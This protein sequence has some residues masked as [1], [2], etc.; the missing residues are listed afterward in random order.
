MAAGMVTRAAR[1]NQNSYLEVQAGNRENKLE[2]MSFKLSKPFPKA[3]L[4]PT[5]PYHLI[6]HK[7]LFSFQMLKR[8]MLGDIL[9]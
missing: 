2:I 1:W 8:Q 6:F 9:I 3:M 7:W 5:S 4:S